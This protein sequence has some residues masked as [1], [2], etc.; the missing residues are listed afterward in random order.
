MATNTRAKLQKARRKDADSHAE[1]QKPPNNGRI[2]QKN[3]RLICKL[4]KAGYPRKDIAERVGIGLMKLK[5]ILTRENCSLQ[6]KWTDD[7]KKEILQQADKAKYNIAQIAR[8]FNMCR[9]TV[10]RMQ[11]LAELTE[12]QRK[13][14]LDLFHRGY[15]R[16]QIVCEVNE[17]ADT[18]AAVIEND[19][20]RSYRERCR[21]K[22]QAQRT[23][24][25]KLRGEGMSGNIIRQQ[26]KISWFRLKQ[27]ETLSQEPTT[28]SAGPLSNTKNDPALESD[29]VEEE[30]VVQ[31]PP[32]SENRLSDA[33]QG[34][35]RSVRLKNRIHGDGDV[36][37]EQVQT[38]P[39]S[40]D[41]H[42][43]TRLVC[44]MQLRSKIMRLPDVEGKQVVQ[45]PPASEDSHN[46][47]EQGSRMSVSSKDMRH[48]DVQGEHVID[49]LTASEDSPNITQQGCR[50]SARLKAMQR[51]DPG[52]Q[53]KPACYF[54]Y[55]NSSSSA[56]DQRITAK[57]NAQI[58]GEISED[59]D[60]RK[61][62]KYTSQAIMSSD[63]EESQTVTAVHSHQ[64]L[65]VSTVDIQRPQPY[66]S[67]ASSAPKRQHNVTDNEPSV[68]ST[69][70]TSPALPIPITQTLPIE[71]NW[72]D[73]HYLAQQPV[74][75]QLH[76]QGYSC[77]SAMQHI[78]VGLQSKH[79]PLRAVSSDAV[80][81]DFHNKESPAIFQLP[82]AQPSTAIVEDDT[83]VTPVAT[84]CRLEGV[85]NIEQRTPEAAVDHITTG[86]FPTL[87]EPEGM[88][89][90]DRQQSYVTSEKED[91]ISGQTRTGD[92]DSLPNDNCAVEVHS[93]HS[94]NGTAGTEEI[95]SSDDC[96]VIESQKET[97][98]SVCANNRWLSLDDYFG[99]RYYQQNAMPED[100]HVA[101]EVPENISS[102]TSTE[103]G[104]FA[105]TATL[106]TGVS[107]DNTA[108]QSQEMANREISQNLEMQSISLKLCQQGSSSEA[109]KQHL[110]VCFL[111]DTASMQDDSRVDEGQDNNYEE[112][113]PIDQLSNAQPSTAIRDTES[114]VTP[115]FTFSPFE[116]EDA[117]DTEQQ[118]SDAVEDSTITD[119]IVSPR[120]ECMS[121]EGLQQ[122][123]H[124]SEH[125]SE[126]GIDVETDT[127]Q[128]PSS[129]ISVHPTSSTSLSRFRE[130]NSEMLLLSPENAT[131]SSVRARYQCHI[132]RLS[133]E[134]EDAFL[135]HLAE[136]Q[137]AELFATGVFL[138][139]TRCKFK[140]RKPATMG[141][142][143]VKYQ[144]QSTLQT[145]DIHSVT[146]FH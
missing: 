77:A 49:T 15:S 23:A 2:D 21:Q 1:T 94:E 111:S 74:V 87:P 125:I 115:V 28:S 137:H 36:E 16:A 67:E 140:T 90:E 98:A 92:A 110:A 34:C 143:I 113:N 88:P 39:A 127:I 83:C 61:L 27:L 99:M 5:N 132:C 68:E 4:R 144:S 19:R 85:G 52:S 42:K 139:C 107:A 59:E 129:E 78:D 44:R 145:S 76:I 45:K 134:E 53:R 31:T 9:S 70:N 50:R 73:S 105:N 120:P 43:N 58:P 81:R 131:T 56:H 12:E 112:A 33:V 6:K 69:A 135:L 25:L 142:H 102:G 13:T 65:S 123:Y 72:D 108:P 54:G 29:D 133:C 24:V 75:S 37:G 35:R 97:T 141:K 126:A 14:I 104:E 38:Q 55:Y 101:T 60:V 3:R 62:P 30:Q 47:I 41:S 11:R 18:V 64:I 95:R 66:Y 100:D 93:P 117:F 103:P 116:E 146:T 46:N 40:E 128:F 79:T 32:A 109:M 122:P 118:Q 17:T 7:E 91:S 26:L 130:A 8:Q 80:E 84:L 57:I 10:K 20:M 114:C 124:P 86:P 106:M 138:Y 82:R 119:P 96:R 71:T 22:Y 48:G 63:S 89:S 51:G 121:S 136:K